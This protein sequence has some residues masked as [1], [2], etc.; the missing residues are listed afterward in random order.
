MVIEQA[1]E[2]EADQLLEGGELIYAAYALA[3]RAA[4]SVGRVARL[5]G[6]AANVG[7]R[8][9]RRLFES[10]L[11][12]PLRAGFDVL[13]ERGE[14]A[15]GALAEEGRTEANRSRQMARDLTQ[16]LVGTTA[17]GFANNPG[18]N[19]VIQG[20]AKCPA[21]GEGKP[22]IQQPAI[23]NQNIITYT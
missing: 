22:G 5:A 7:P 20:Q 23:E 15:V 18:V 16:D 21:A 1:P 13:V 6:S 11:F 2:D 9:V 14:E 19:R 12:A 8:P 4:R 17:A 10:R 3:D